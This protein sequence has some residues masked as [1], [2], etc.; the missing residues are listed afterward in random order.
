MNS[1]QKNTLTIIFIVFAF[2]S[3]ILL[4]YWFAQHK[5]SIESRGTS[6]KGN[7]ITPPV[8]INNLP[9]LDPLA[10]ADYEL[11]GKWNLIY[12]TNECS[13]DCI[14][15][16]YRMR[17]IHTAMDKHSLRV[18]RVLLMTTADQTEIDSQ[19]QEYQGQRIINISA[20]ERA[21]LLQKFKL[22][23]VDDPLKLNRLYIIDPMG[24]LMMS[25]PPDIDPRDIMK[26]M[27]K[28]L[29]FSRIG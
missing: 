11:Y 8:Q 14:N 26:D 27:K 7:L 13:A 10:N 12:V 9:L 25:Y 17:Q 4:S 5:E 16:L 23:E 2:L 15:N 6:N 20:E 3:P 18:Q 19:L 28:L 1:K 29:K 21:T 24:N 22:N